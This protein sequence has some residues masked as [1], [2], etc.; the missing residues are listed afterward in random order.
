MPPPDVAEERIEDACRAYFEG[1]LVRRSLS[2]AQIESQS[3]AELEQ[4]LVHVDEAIE[5]HEEFGTLSIK[6]SSAPDDELPQE[7]GDLA[8]GILPLLLE[9]KGE[10]LRRICVVRP[11][12]RLTDLKATVERSMDDS[13]LRQE[14]IGAINSMSAQ[15]AADTRTLQLQ[16]A[17]TE[18]QRVVA[19][20]DIE[21][22]ER[23]VA[24]QERRNKMLKLWFERES[25]AS[26][27]GAFLLLVLGLALITAM[28][29]GTPTSE[30]VTS[31]FLLILGYF[32]GQATQAQKE[33]TRKRQQV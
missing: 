12:A 29:V 4:S 23:K 2:R 14:F 1:A 17:Q 6:V 24:V 9:T 27:I 7:Q 18:R 13:T 5:H 26:I 21:M 11:Q 28:F 33:N 25:L 30:V 32:F 15:V 16:V 20:S 19:L 8:I 3:L 22:A 31:S 10:I